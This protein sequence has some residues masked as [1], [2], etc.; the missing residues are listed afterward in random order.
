MILQSV[1][2]V[3]IFET[4]GDWLCGCSAQVSRP[5]R[6]PTP[7]FKFRD[8]YLAPAGIFSSD[9]QETQVVIL[10]D[11]FDSEAYQKT[12]QGVFF[13]HWIE[14][15]AFLSVFGEYAQLSDKMARMLQHEKNGYE[16]FQKVSKESR[17]IIKK[18]ELP[19][20]LWLRL[21]RYPLAECEIGIRA[22]GEWSLSR[23]EAMQCIEWVCDITDRDGASFSN[24]VH[25]VPPKTAFLCMLQKRFPKHG[26]KQE[27]FD[28]L[29]K[30]FEWQGWRVS[31][32]T[33]FW[34]EGRYHMETQ[35]SS[36]EDALAKLNHMQHIVRDEKFNELCQLLEQS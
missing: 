20:R 35:V 36:K 28:T 15:A 9:S 30:A 26:Q 10:P 5:L 12:Y 16:I 21:M 13:R 33:R 31:P 22:I 27:R 19:H 1:P 17:A 18:K 8:I 23:S 6:V 7:V 32:K 2:I 29:S 11:D 14:R 34:D 25:E 24:W 4:L 3:N